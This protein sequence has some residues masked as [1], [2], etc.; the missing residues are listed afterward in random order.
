MPTDTSN[1]NSSDVRGD[2]LAE[3]RRQ[4]AALVHRL[5]SNQNDF[6]R[7]ARSAWRLQEDERR[8][9]ARELHDGIGQNLTALKHQLA[10]VQASLPPA[11]SE[12]AARLD[13]SIALCG[14]TLED[15]R[16]LSRLLRPQILDDLGLAPALQWLVRSLGDAGGLRVELDLAAVPTLDAEL[17][18]LVFRIAQEALSNVVR[19][20]G[21]SHAVVRLATRAPGLWLTVWD[22][23][24]RWRIGATGDGEARGD[25]SGLT[26]MR[27]R[28]E[29]YGGRLQVES[30][31]ASGT[32][33]RAVLPLDATDDHA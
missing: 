25:G 18:T 31:P 27:E 11:Q 28:L 15:T 21:A 5:E 32:W 1:G 22:D 14:Q 33:L 12:L 24:G 4:Y 3:L 13:A 7:L 20:A 2:S 23:G 19:H 8:R 9:I 16:Q 6:R 30:D 17:Q 10:A 26:N 29:A